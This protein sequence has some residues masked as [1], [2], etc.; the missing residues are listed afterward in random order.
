M[1]KNLH[2]ITEHESE[3]AVGRVHI[4]KSKHTAKNEEGP[5][6]V[7]RDGDFKT[8]GKLVGMGHVDYV[9]EDDLEE[10]IPDLIKTRLEDLD[11]RWLQKAGIE[12]QTQDT[13]T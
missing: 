8:I 2:L 13:P 6:Q 7:Y 5:M 10:R 4:T 9:D 12:N 3:D 1:Q 11:E